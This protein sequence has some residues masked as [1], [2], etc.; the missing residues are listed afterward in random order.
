LA[1]A[2]E[3]L[4]RDA[5][6]VAVALLRRSLDEQASDPPRATLLLKLG[7]V[8]LTR[9]NPAAAEILHEAREASD[10]IRERALA[11]I[12]LAESL[13]FGGDWDAAAKIT[14]EALDDLHGLSPELALELELGRALVCAFDPALA[15]NFWHDRARL[16]SLARGESWPARALSAA[17]AMTSAFGSEHVDEVLP[18]CDH[19]LADGVLLTERGAGAFAPGHVMSALATLDLHERA[20]AFADELETAARAQGS[21]ANVIVATLTRGTIAMRRGDLAA[22]EELLSP[23]IETAAQNGM[24]LI[25]VNSLFLSTDAILERPS[26]EPLAALVESLELP[27]AVAEA[28]GGAWVLSTRGRLRALRGARADA[29]ADL[30]VA[31]R[32][33]DGLHFGPAHATS[34]SELALVL[35]PE[36]REEALALVQEELTLANAAGLARPRGIVLRASGLIAGGDDGIELLRESVS[37]LAGLPARYEHA[38]SLVELGAALRRSAR[39][40]DSREPLEAGMELAHFCGAER[41]V[42]RAREELL[43]AGAR[44]RNIVRS[45]FVALTASERRIARLAADGRSNPEIAQALYV[46][47]KTVETH[48][49]NAYR[50]LDLSGPGARGRLLKLVA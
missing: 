27:P 12:G 45:G 33:F 13:V 44:P 46:S 14:E 22:A 2:D 25:L 29:E 36:D 38:C 4:A 1:A 21:V 42:G 32:I 9:R 15:P 24:L 50:K 5:P 41:L 3:A 28:S 43:A 48:L 8:E 20:L 47:V 37:L 34:R 39:R 10:D 26:Q 7:Q 18:L 11:A 40:A 35:R 19:A 23:L 30:R 16:R 6:E 49:S 31:A 17:L